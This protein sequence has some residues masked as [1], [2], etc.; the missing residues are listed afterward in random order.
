MPLETRN[1]A[2]F[3]TWFSEQVEKDDNP[4]YGSSDRA[5]AIRSDSSRGLRTAS[6]RLRKGPKM[7]A[8]PTLPCWHLA[9]VKRMAPVPTYTDDK[10]K[11]SSGFLAEQSKWGKFKDGVKKQ[12][13]P[14]KSNQ[15]DAS[16]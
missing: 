9:T 16:E 4:K 3:L 1:I 7:V 5:K 14:E 15:D 11:K 6:D 10:D 13:A 12:F 8:N 2:N